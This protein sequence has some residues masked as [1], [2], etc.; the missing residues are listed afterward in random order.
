MTELQ[1]AKYWRRWSAVVRANQW[2]MVRNRLDPNATR[3][4]SPHHIA[5]FAAAERLA[6]Q[7]ACAVTA[8]HLRHGCHI[9]AIGRDKSHEDLT[10]KEFDALLNYWGDERRVVGLLIEPLDLGSDIHH[11]HPELKIRERQMHF[12]RNDCLPGYVISECA[13]LCGTKDW[14]TL[15]DADLEKL[16]DFLRTRPHALK[17]SVAASSSRRQPDPELEPF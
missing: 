14:T 2:R 1:S 13:R 9:I 8:G 12:I 11:D 7:E 16:H 5:V 3:D 4:V 15:N 17:T 6:L 10:N